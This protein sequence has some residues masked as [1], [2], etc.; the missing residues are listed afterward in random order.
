MAQITTPPD[1]EARPAGGAEGR[2]PRRP[3]AALL[4]VGVPLDLLAIAAALAALCAATALR[5]AGLDAPLFLALNGWRAVPDALWES[6]GV[7]GLGV[8]AF[9]VLSVLAHRHHRVIAALPWMLLVGG[10]L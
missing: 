1:A 8:A 2:A 3:L 9:V 7:A 6:L 5:R 4:R 10:G